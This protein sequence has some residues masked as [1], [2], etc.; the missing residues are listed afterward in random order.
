MVH[1]DPD[2]MVFVP[3]AARPFAR[4]VIDV[5]LARAAQEMGLADYYR[6]CVRPVLRAPREQWPSCC[7]STCEPC[8]ELLVRVARRTVELLGAPP[9]L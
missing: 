8:N 4:S 2:E 6:D 7:Q 5:A 9:P 3:V 1:A